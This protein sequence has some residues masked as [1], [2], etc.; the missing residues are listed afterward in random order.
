[1]PNAELKLRTLCAADDEPSPGEHFHKCRACS[2]VWKHDD[3]LAR[4]PDCTEAQFAEAHDCPSCGL[5]ER[6]KFWPVEPG[7]E[8][9]LA[10]LIGGR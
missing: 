4:D 6:E 3:S 5:N 2:T 10:S 7:I 1:M 8:H 9:L